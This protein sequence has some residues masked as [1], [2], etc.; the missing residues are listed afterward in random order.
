MAWIFLMDT[1]RT[2]IVFDGLH[3]SY[4]QRNCRG[5]PT[6]SGSTFNSLHY[7]IPSIS[8]PSSRN[9]G[10]NSGKLPSPDP[11][12]RDTLHSTSGSYGSIE[13]GNFLLCWLHR[14]GHGVHVACHV[15]YSVLTT[16]A[17]ADLQLSLVSTSFFYNFLL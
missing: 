11:Q 2:Y 8:M 12:P 1:D 15:P 17:S 6:K 5:L 4:G 10:S 16:V 3:F 14:Y 13:D 9:P 7:C